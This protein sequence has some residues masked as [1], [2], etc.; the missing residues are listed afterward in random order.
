VAGA[1]SALCL[2][3]TARALRAP[4]P[5]RLDPRTDAH[6]IHLLA[7]ARA[8]HPEAPTQRPTVLLRH[9]CPACHA[10]VRTLA[11]RARAHL[12]TL[13]I[14]V[15]VDR[16]WPELQALADQGMATLHDTPAVRALPVTPAVIASTA[17][18]AMPNTTPVIR[19]GVPDI[20]ALLDTLHTPRNRP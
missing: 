20:I 18:D 9:D 6:T 5:T 14:T 16:R 2:L 17:H 11:R 7:A 1:V 19:Y 12:G 8:A 13:P 15:M 10:L 4:T 3:G